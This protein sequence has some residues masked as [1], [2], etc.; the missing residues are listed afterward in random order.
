LEEAGLEVL[1]LSKMPDIHGKEDVVQRI[2]DSDV[3]QNILDQM[4]RLSLSALHL[5]VCF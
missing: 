3:Q 1:E 2:I 5:A 4:L